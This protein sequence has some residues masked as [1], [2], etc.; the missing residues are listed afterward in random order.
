MEQ[1]DK[2]FSG[3]TPVSKEEWKAKAIEDLKGADFH[4]K[5]VWKTDDGFPVYPFYTR[6]DLT[7]IE[8]IIAEEQLITSAPRHWEQYTIINADDAIAANRQAQALVKCGATGVLFTFSDEG[9]A[10][11]PR[12]LEGL[13]LEEL[14]ISFSSPQP[15]VAFLSEYMGYLEEREI[16]LQSIS[17]FYECDVLE[18]WITT[19]E[20]PDFETVANLL[21]MAE[22]VPNFKTLVVR[23][24]AFVNAGS[25]TAQELAFTLN[26]LTDY[27]DKLTELGLS[28]EVLTRNLLVHLVI[29]GDYFLEIAKFRAM[30]LL[31]NKI[32]ELYGNAVQRIPVLAS[33]ALWSK[34]FYDPNVNLLR[35][36]T[37]SMA[38]VLGGCDALLVQPHDSAFAQ[39]SPFSQRIAMNISNLLREEA[40]L[41]KVAD[42]AAG[43]YYI[44][45][46][47]ANLIHQSLSL[48]K[49]V[50]GLGGFMEA[51][52]LDNIQQKVVQ[53]REK[54]EREI[55]LRKRVYVGTNKYPNPHE[56]AVLP[57]VAT[58]PEEKQEF[59]LLVP[60]RATQKFD[61]L[62]SRTLVHQQKTGYVPQVYLATFGNLTMR[63]A[64]A[65]F[66]A[67]LFG[68]A[69]FKVIG[70]F[71]NTDPAITANEAA[72]S[73]ADIVVICSS[74]TDYE[75]GALSFV[76][77][78]RAVTTD[79]QLVLAGYPEAL[80]QPLKEAGVDA[81]IHI[82]CNAIEVLTHFQNKL[83]KEVTGSLTT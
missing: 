65:S 60:Q 64:R 31:L 46:L 14:S 61:E 57:V 44:E 29:G 11:L 83:F 7:A 23:S 41:D 9:E 34:S 53:A 71:Y 12:L 76:Q 75:T 24:G 38:A 70:E 63:K 33:N 8:P 10:D 72:A 20:E 54:K 77:A 74:D 5:L 18:Q 21:K 1:T 16:D 47:T 39:P 58:Q 2:L 50:E 73:E 3:F 56:K 27:L 62:R 22:G 82:K 13:N 79:K 68:V 80:L 66:A 69:G 81:F 30:R 36:T 49:E 4:Q 48:F 52:R 26:K 35:N 40:Y 45:S 19:G 25:T 15:S 59:P 55:A 28:K 17:G 37:E 67:E 78:F 6:E 42:P 51:F 43:C 32:L